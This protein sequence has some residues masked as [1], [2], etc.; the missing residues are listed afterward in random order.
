MRTTQWLAVARM[1]VFYPAWP[2][3]QSHVFGVTGIAPARA[4]LP[5]GA[6]ANDACDSARLLAP[7]RAQPI[8]EHR[9][10]Q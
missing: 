6:H 9:S 10:C 8:K 1:T 5:V 7:L 3:A 4:V 2:I